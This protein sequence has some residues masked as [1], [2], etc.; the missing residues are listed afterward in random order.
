MS[1]NIVPDCA[2]CPLSPTDRIC[3]NRKGKGHKGCPTL[4]KKVLTEEAREEYQKGEV[5]EFARQASIQEAECYGGRG[6]KGAVLYPTKPRIQEIC[7]FATKMGYRRLGFVF[8]E[9]LLQEGKLVAQIL[10][11]QGFEVVSAVCKVGSIPKEEIGIRDDEKIRIGEYEPMCNPILQAKILNDSKTEFNI[12]MG[13]CVG[14]DAL[15]FKYADAPT[16]VLA[17]KDRITG[18]NP[19]SAIY[20]SHSYYKKLLIKGF[21]TP[22]D[23]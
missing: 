15:F 22:D 7:E 16:T 2:G 3:V 13:L 11:A 23:R 12:A 17:A 21:E 10:K 8:C 9:G 20:T 14:H 18:H 5:A 1:K 19:L 4:T 6:K